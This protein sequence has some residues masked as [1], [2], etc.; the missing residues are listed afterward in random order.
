MQSSVHFWERVDR[1]VGL[2]RQWCT[3]GKGMEGLLGEGP[4]MVGTG[5]QSNGKGLGSGPP[6]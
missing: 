1:Q 4:A 5:V 3:P 6:V 2:G